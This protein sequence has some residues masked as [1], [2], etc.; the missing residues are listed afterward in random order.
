MLPENS[1]FYKTQLSW[2]CPGETLCLYMM[3]MCLLAYLKRAF[4][5]TQNLRLFVPDIDLCNRS[6]F[7]PSG[8]KWWVKEMKLAVFFNWFW[9]SSPFE[10]EDSYCAFN[11]ERF[12]QVILFT[13]CSIKKNTQCKCQGCSFCLLKFSIGH[14]SIERNLSDPSARHKVLSS[15]NVTIV[16]CRQSKLH[17]SPY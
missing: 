12:L 16:S 3:L 10:G 7:L 17:F 4:L 9:S 5:G 6:T 2:E 15:T 1:C 13:F 14:R 8:L 11:W